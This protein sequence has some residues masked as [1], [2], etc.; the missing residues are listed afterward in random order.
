[1]IAYSEM[2]DEVCFAIQDSGVGIDPEQILNL[3]SVFTKIKENRE[4]NKQG[5]GLGLTISKNLATALGGD[6]IV[7]SERGK[8]STFTLTLRHSAL[9]FPG[10]S[11]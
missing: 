3:F 11:R 6:I 9:I 4:M 10:V 7:T 2:E 1:M 5:C 8:G